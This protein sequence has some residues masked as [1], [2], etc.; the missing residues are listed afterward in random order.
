MA[1][2]AEA[3]ISPE[4]YLRLERRSAMRNEY[5]DGR[6][7]P[8]VEG[9]SAM[10][11]ARRAH[12]LIAG[13]VGGALRGRLRGRDCETYEAEMRVRVD[14]ANRYTY[15]DVAVAC[16]PEFEDGVEDTLLNPLVVFD[17]LSPSTEGYDRGPKFDLYEGVASIQEIVFVRQDRR[18][19]ERYRRFGPRQWLREWFAEGEVALESLGVS[20]PFD[21]VYERVRFDPNPPFR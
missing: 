16:G 8:M 2:P 7:V 10:A 15:P 20:L 12:V 6:I 9:P 18:H 1:Q 5:L 4:E 13:N 14:E 3:W 11:G 21:E 19:I 17:I